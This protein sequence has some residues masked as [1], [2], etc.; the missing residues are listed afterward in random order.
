MAVSDLNDVLVPRESFDATLIRHWC[1]LLA[2]AERLFE[3]RDFSVAVV[4]AQTACEVV[5]ERA[6]IHAFSRKGIA[7]LEEPVTRF[8][9]TYALQRDDNRLLYDALTADEIGKKS[10]WSGYTKLVKHRNDIVH[11]GQDSNQTDARTDLDSARLFVQHVAQ[12]N[13]LQ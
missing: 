11:S 5:T 6:I 10:F 8:L 7:E 13:G 9:R 4:V 3:T 1:K 12:H 2:T